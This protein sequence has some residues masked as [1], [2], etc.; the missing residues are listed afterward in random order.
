MGCAASKRIEMVQGD[1]LKNGNKSENEIYEG[2]P[3]SDRQDVKQPVAEDENGNSLMSQIKNNDQAILKQH[4]EINITNFDQTTAVGHEA[5]GI[6]LKSTN[7]DLNGE[8][9]LNGNVDDKILILHFNDVYNIEPRE[10]EPVGGAARFASKI[11]TF[12]PRNPL[13]LFSGDALNPSMSEIILLCNKKFKFLEFFWPEFL[14]L[15][16]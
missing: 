14:V 8:T 15:L 16:T 6:L 13:I 4:N 1:R 3:T 12:K 10:K 2:P 5:D 11:A 7:M 9:V